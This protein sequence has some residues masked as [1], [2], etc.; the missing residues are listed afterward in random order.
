MS[1]E[2]RRLAR[3]PVLALPAIGRLQALPLEIRAPLAAL[4]AELASDARS[5]AEE[6]W[7]RHKAPMAAY[8]KAVSVYAGH[9]RKALLQE[10]IGRAEPLFCALA[11]RGSPTRPTGVS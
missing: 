8:W 6:S 4:L 10:Q 3:N 11:R 5:R 7:R 9:I 1:C 2:H